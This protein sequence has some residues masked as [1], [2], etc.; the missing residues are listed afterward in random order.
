MQFYLD[1]ARQMGKC[2]HCRMKDIEKEAFEKKLVVSIR[3]DDK[4]GGI[5]G[6]N[7]F[8]HPS[9]VDIPWGIQDGQESKYWKAWM[10]QI[11]DECVCND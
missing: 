5:V 7:V 6:T 4:C 2:N 10:W 8:V 1:G 11:T 3:P 9:T